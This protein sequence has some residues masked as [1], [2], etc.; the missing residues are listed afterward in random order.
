MSN[1]NID[2]FQIARTQV[3]RAE[4]TKWMDRIGADE[5]E[6]RAPE[7]KKFHYDDTVASV[8]RHSFHGE[9]SA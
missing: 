6:S 2:V 8:T 9:E 1:V 7:N 5:Y 3:D 4:V